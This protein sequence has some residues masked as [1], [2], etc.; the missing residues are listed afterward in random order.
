M[1]KQIFFRME[2]DAAEYE[3]IRRRLE[4]EFGGES[5]SNINRQ[6]WGLKKRDRAK[7]MTG[8]RNKKFNLGSR[9]RQLKLKL[10]GADGTID[11]HGIERRF[12][13]MLDSQ[14]DEESFQR[15]LEY[16]LK[17]C[18]QHGIP[19]NPQLI[20][21]DIAKFLNGDEEIKQF[22]AKGFWRRKGE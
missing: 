9:I 4:T 5:F 6:M 14:P 2:V 20:N 15:N 22:W 8:N 11:P 13:A 12:M 1:A 16:F 18:E 7:S 17:M 10:S 3:Q 19:V 21:E